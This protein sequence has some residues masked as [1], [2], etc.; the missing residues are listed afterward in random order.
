MT[1]FIAHWF[2]K[3][4]GVLLIALGASLCARIV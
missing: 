2:N 3:L 4:T 1:S